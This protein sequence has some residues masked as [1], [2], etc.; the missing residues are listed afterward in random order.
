MML[1]FRACLVF[2]SLFFVSKGFGQIPNAG[3]E[4]W[5]PIQNCQHPSSWYDFY[6]LVDSSGTYCPISHSIRISNDTALWNTS[7]PPQSWLG[8]GMVFSSQLNDKPLFPV[9]NHPKSLCGYYKFQP[10]NGDTL[11]IRLF[12]YKNGVE[13]AGAKFTSNAAAP[14]WTAFKVF[15]EDTNYTSVDSGRITL[16]TANEP[17]DGSRGPLGNSVLWVDNLSFD[18]PITAVKNNKIAENNFISVH[19][20]RNELWLDWPQRNAQNTGVFLYDPNGKLIIQ[21]IWDGNSNQKRM[22]AK[23]MVEGI[24]FLKL[25]PNNGIPLFKRILIGN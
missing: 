14:D 25:K 1:F 5:R 20:S 13:I 4:D 19:S 22:A 24:Y 12:L 7:T 15:M 16:S 9:E 18:A 11:N 8:W 6:S 23:S 17:K 3:F 21:D 10:Q 2:L